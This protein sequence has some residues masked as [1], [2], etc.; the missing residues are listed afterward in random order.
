MLLNIIKENPNELLKMAILLSFCPYS[1]PRVK[2]NLNFCF[3]TSLCLFKKV[4]GLFEVLQR[5]VKIKIYVNFISTEIFETLG[6][7]GVKSVK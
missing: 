3:Y 1:G 4:E 7:V 6:A 2:I 5:N